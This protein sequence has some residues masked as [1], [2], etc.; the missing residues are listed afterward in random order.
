MKKIFLS[1]ISCV[2][3]YLMPLAQEKLHYWNDSESYL[4]DQAS[5]IIEQ[6]YNVLTAHPPGTTINS[7]RQ[8]ALASLD[9]LLHDTRLDNGTAFLAFMNQMAGK[10]AGEL[11]QNKPTGREI[12]VFRFYNHGFVVQTQQVT[13]AIDLI[14]GGRP[15][16]PFINESL[17]RSIVEQ[18]DILFITHA[19]GD[20]TDLSVINMFAEQGKD[21][22]LPEPVLKE[23]N[24]PLRVMRGDDMITETIHLQTKNLSL[25]VSVFPGSQGN[26]LNNVYM[27]TLP[28]GQTIMHTGDQDFSED[29]A[30]KAGACNIDILFVQC[31][32]LPMDKFVAGV[33]PA[34]VITGHEN[35]M[36]HTIDHREAYWLTFRRISEITAPYVI[37]AWGESYNIM[38]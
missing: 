28:D 2:I 26:I 37:M 35:E 7:E 16:E 27:I 12:R 20:H 25:P 31:W 22:I 8:L 23:M 4:Q 18:C 6:A 5:F 32:M 33:K 15:N 10:V 36:L 17:M 13:I 24:P 1:I 21:V 38:P 11:Q 30:A 3:P 14:R 29:L 9:A 19:H 34:L